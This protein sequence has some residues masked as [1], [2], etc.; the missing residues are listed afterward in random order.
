MGRAWHNPRGGARRSP[1][2]DPVHRSSGPWERAGLR[3]ADAPVRSGCSAAADRRVAARRSSRPRAPTARR[4]RD[5]AQHPGTDGRRDRFDRVAQHRAGWLDRTEFRIKR[6]RPPDRT[7]TDRLTVASCAVAPTRQRPRHQQ[8]MS[9]P[10][11]PADR[12]IARRGR[13]VRDPSRARIARGLAYPQRA[14][15]PISVGP[16]LHTPRQAGRSP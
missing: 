2:P 12:P 4:A 7:G 13:S 9:A 8:H 5:Q 15:G 11:C 6:V 10:A 16:G 14:S 1:V 3:A